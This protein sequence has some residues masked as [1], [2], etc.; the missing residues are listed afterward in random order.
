M[1]TAIAFDISA[2]LENIVCDNFQ[3]YNA[4]SFHS[5]TNE[6]VSKSAITGWLVSK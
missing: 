2:F 4:D 1:F 5:F 3:V 6:V